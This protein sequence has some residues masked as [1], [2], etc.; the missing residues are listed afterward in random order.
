MSEQSPQTPPTSVLL[1]ELFTAD[2]VRTFLCE[3]E[4]GMLT[5]T[6]TE[7]LDGLCHSKKMV[8]E[9]VIK[10]AGIERTFGHQLFRGARKFSRDNTIRLAFGFGLSVEETQELLKAAR[11]APLYPRIKRDAVI[12]YGLSHNQS[13]QDIQLTLGELGLTLLGGE[14]YE[15]SER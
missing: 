5:P 8:R 2:D 1:E 7:Y 3:N 15:H 10:N 11:K 14:K 12:I 9:R 4:D 6:F 13:V